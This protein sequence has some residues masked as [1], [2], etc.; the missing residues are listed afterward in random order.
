MV[1]GK[2]NDSFTGVLH[3]QGWQLMRRQCNFKTKKAETLET[4]IF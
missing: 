1:S 4:S 3:L 2:K